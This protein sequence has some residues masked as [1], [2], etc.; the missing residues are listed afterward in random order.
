[1]TTALLE[2]ME[3]RDSIV[4]LAVLL[5]PPLRRRPAVAAWQLSFAC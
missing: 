3:R 4:V 1:M 5:A 2:R